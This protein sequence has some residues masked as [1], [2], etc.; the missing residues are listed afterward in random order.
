MALIHTYFGSDALGMCV[1][2]DVIIPVRSSETAVEGERFKT[3]WLL[4]GMSDDNTIWQ[5]RTSIERYAAE[6]GLAVVMPAACLSR[7]S[8]QAH[9]EHYYTYIARELPETMR[10]YFPLSDKREDN[11]IAGLSMGGEGAMK[12]GLANP[13][14]YS[15]IGCLSAGAKNRLPDYKPTKPAAIHLD[16]IIY[17]DRVLEGTPEDPCGLVKK[18]VDDKKPLPR[19]YHACGSSDSLLDA[20]H[21]TRDFFNGFK[22]NPFDYVFEEDPGAH[23]WEFWDEHIQRFIR[24]LKLEKQTSIH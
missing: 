17:G 19:I 20:A 24:Y 2:C 23:T 22:G 21:L 13:E 8:D 6:Y 5:R 7:Y 3:L 14:N 18:L 1:N 12:I 16:E 4:H 9:G 10:R 11:F 15:V